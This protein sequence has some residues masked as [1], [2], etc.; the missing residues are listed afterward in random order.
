MK[1]AIRLVV[2]ALVVSLSL[3]LMA[4]VGLAQGKTYIIASDNSFA[5]F[6]FLDVATNAYTGVDM[7]LLSAIAAEQGFVYEVQ[8]VG[9][10]A[11]MG[12]V[13]AGQ[14]DGMIAGMT[15]T[16]A[17]KETY[18]FSDGYFEDGQVMVVAAASQI[19]SLEGLKGTVV[20]VKTSTQGATY[21]ESISGE[22]GFTLQYYEDSPT[23]YTAVINGTNSACFEDRTVVEWAIKTEGLSLK[24]VGDVINPKYYGFAV[25]KGVNPELIEMFNKG[26]SNIR[27]NGMY[28]EILAKYGF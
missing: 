21:A 8:N 4:C 25:K 1:T 16:D 19:A 9:F 7:D 10:D 2:I 28:D 27:D 6:E 12:A 3:G 26:L 18:D 13:Q 23:M 22:Y 15:I 17:R 24:T 11:A 14:A 20:A 5:P